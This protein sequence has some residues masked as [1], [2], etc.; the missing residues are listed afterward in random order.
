MW[1]EHVTLLD[2]TVK[3]LLIGIVASAPMGPV[4]VL[5]IQRTLNKG[6]HYGMPPSA[7]SST[8]WPQASA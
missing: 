5:C 4:G 2:L 6:R 7:T 8:L 3:G 1:F